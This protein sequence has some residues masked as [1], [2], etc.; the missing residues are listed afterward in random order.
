MVLISQAVM[1]WD[2]IAE[3][4][5]DFGPL[6]VAARSIGSQDFYRAEPYRDFFLER[7]GG[8]HESLRFTRPPFYAVLLWPLGHLSYEAA[9]ATF[10]VLRLL[11]G[12]AFVLLW[13]CPSRRAAAA[14]AIICFPYWG[15]FINGQ[16]GPFLLLFLG[17]AWRF[18][19]DDKQTSAGL[20]LS[21]CSIKWHL[22]LTLPIWLLAKS[23][24]KALQGFCVGAAA[25]IA[26]SF[27]AQGP[28]WP[29]EYAEL[30]LSP[31]IS[32]NE[33]SMPNLHSVLVGLP[34]GIYLEG[35]AVLA[36]FW[37][38]WMA[39]SR[40]DWSYSLAAVLVGGTLT[41]YHAYFTD[42]ML[43]LPAAI[44]L[45]NF[46]HRR[47]LRTLSLVMLIPAPLLGNRPLTL[48]AVLIFLG[49]FF[50]MAMS[51]PSRDEQGLV[52]NVGT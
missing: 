8:T 44:L 14:A 26:L 43:F 30:L 27:A 7:F 16:D 13:R 36:V 46:D 4:S 37:G 20:A 38:A 51:P 47:L 23:R 12:L 25:W 28:R 41:S 10:S 5:N 21:L 3:G 48:M 52:A 34:A 15:A 9:N 35:V 39:S 29:M 49:I 6:Y 45:R 42:C 31:D 24:R 18:F 1:N 19:E 2:T 17:L 11:S 40:A 22:F 33:T 32:P 50:T